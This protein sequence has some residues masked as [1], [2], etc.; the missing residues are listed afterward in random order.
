MDRCS[1]EL[2]NTTSK[3]KKTKK[4]KKRKKKKEKISCSVQSEHVVNLKAHTLILGLFIQKCY[5][6]RAEHKNG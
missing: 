4:R 1:F 2:I 6:V 3:K 5:Q